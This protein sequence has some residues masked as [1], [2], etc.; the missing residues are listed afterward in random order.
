MKL[1]KI[2]QALMFIE[3]FRLKPNIG[4]NNDKRKNTSNNLEKD[5]KLINDSMVGK[6]KKS[7][8]NTVNVRLDMNTKYYQKLGSKTTF[9]SQYIRESFDSCSQD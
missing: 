3:S 8:K 1:K 5:L 9:I 6:T 4:F 7:L 2:H